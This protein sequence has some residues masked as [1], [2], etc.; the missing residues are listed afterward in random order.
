[1]TKEMADL[2][3]NEGI[4][5]HFSPPRSQQ[6]SGLYESVVK[7][8][9]DHLI[10]VIGNNSLTFDEYC[11]LWTQMVILELLSSKRVITYGN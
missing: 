10:R 8:V 2:F 9:K 3:P 7:S 1:M 5:Y 4:T 6:H 11:T